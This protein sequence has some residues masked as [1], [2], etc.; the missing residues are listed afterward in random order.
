MAVYTLDFNRE[1]NPSL[2]EITVGDIIRHVS[3]D[4][5]T[6]YNMFAGTYPEVSLIPITPGT[7]LYMKHGPGC[8][9]VNYV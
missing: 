3:T 1:I 7:D 5:H 8:S 4:P 2:P 6:L 9:Y